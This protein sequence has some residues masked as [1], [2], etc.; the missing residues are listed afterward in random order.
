MQTRHLVHCEEPHGLQNSM[1]TTPQVGIQGSRWGCDHWIPEKAD[2]SLFLLSKGTQ[3][4]TRDSK[5]W[6]AQNTSVTS[7]WDALNLRSL[8]A[9]WGGGYKQMVML[10]PYPLLA[11]H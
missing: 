7:P 10:P 4:L 3:E 5:S 2:L 6:M 11:S 8:R 9:S 1:L